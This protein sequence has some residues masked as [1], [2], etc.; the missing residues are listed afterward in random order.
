MTSAGGR[1]RVRAWDE[2]RIREELG[3]FLEGRDEWPAYRV[4]QRAGLKSLRDSITRNG[5]AQRWAAELG[6]R[7]VYHAPGYLPRWTEDRIRSE[8]REFVDGAEH[9]PSRGE[10]EANGRR[11][12]YD[13]IRRNGGA[14]RWSA[15]VG[16]ARRTRRQGNR[17]GW[18]VEVIEAELSRLIA[19]DGRWPPRARFAQ[20][21]LESMLTAIYVHE[22]V[23]YWADRMG[24][25]YRPRP[26]QAR[27][28]VWSVERI[29]G[30]LELFCEGRLSWPTEREFFAA[31]LGR[32][33]RAASRR[34]GIAFWAAE[35]G[36]RR[37][38]RA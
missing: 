18:T 28:R 35:L 29:R 5:G 33:Y 30:D 20:A 13:A 25:D 15:E 7:H 1:R 14:E 4:F 17:R 11:A 19:G 23:A 27:R 26:S 2:A 6:V 22:G 16:L 36:L 10:F 37:G 31:G 12:L 32:L 21:G 38:R 3:R 34:G 9:W 8:L 24:V